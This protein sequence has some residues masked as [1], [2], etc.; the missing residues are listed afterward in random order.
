MGRQ[1]S[2]TVKELVPRPIYSKISRFRRLSTSIYQKFAGIHKRE[3]PVCNYRGYFAGRGA[4][5]RFDAVCP[6]CGSLERHRQHF[7]LLSSNPSWIDGARLLHFA[8][9]PCFVPEYSR[10]ASLY[11]RADLFAGAGETRVDIQQMQFADDSF[12]TTICHQIMEHIPDDEAAMRELYR[13]TCPGGIVILS[14]PVVHTWEKTYI[15][16][17]VTNDE[18]RDLHFGQRDHLRVYGRDF[19]SLIERAG[20]SL[21]EDIAFEPNVSRYSLLRGDIIYIAK[22][23][24]TGGASPGVP[25]KLPAVIAPAA[26]AEVRD[27]AAVQPTTMLIPARGAP[28]AD[29]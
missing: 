18:E 28:E 4:P 11:V 27:G 19:R 25:T 7:L 2:L 12:D 13:V 24:E 15:N 29:R 10:R 9:E 21:S 1:R 14:T 5:L 16:T 3:C 26:T 20:F 23:A 8:A 22:K 17:S 6:N